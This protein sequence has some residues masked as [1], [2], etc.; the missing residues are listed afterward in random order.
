M[1]GGGDLILVSTSTNIGLNRALAGTT[2]DSERMTN[3]FI[4]TMS[5]K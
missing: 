4:V 2:D 1:S 5:L 3:T